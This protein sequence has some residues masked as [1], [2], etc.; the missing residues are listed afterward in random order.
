MIAA[1]MGIGLTL[2]GAALVL[3]GLRR[4]ALVNVA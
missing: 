4:R 1:G 3:A 2:V